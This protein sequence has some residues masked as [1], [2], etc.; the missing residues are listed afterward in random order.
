MILNLWRNWKRAI[1]GGEVQALNGVEYHAI[2]DG[3]CRYW[4]PWDEGRLIPDRD[5]QARL[6][7]ACGRYGGAN[8]R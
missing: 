2:D 1:L 8:G 6:N 7:A 3:Q 5:F 4:T